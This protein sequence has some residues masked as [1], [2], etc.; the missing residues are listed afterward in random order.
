MSLTPN[1]FR[2]PPPP[3]PT[4]DEEEDPTRVGHVRELCPLLLQCEHRRVIVPDSDG[5]AIASRVGQSQRSARQRATDRRG[6][7]GVRV[8]V[9]RERR[10]ER[11]FIWEGIGVI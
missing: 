6:R 8:N 5:S 4:E 7:D 10:R 9:G 1:S 2:P 3:P 11:G